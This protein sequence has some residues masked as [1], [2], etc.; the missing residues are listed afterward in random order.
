MVELR[1]LYC[2]KELIV[3]G[4]QGSAKMEALLQILVDILLNRPRKYCEKN[5]SLD[6]CLFLQL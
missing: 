5:R 6:A 3:N 2:Y 4:E 1:L